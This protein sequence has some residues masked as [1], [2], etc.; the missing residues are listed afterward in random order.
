MNKS[1]LIVGQREISNKY[2]PYIIAEISA[3]H[4]GSI[5]CAKN[6]IMAA[7]K[8]GVHA[9]KIQTYTPDTMTIDVQKDD[10]L[11]QK[12]L[13][14][15]RSLYDLY[16]EAYTPF[17]WHKSLFSF[18][19]DINVTLFSSPFDE[20]AVDLLESLDVPA[21][22]IA[23]FEIVDLPLIRYV[24]NKQKPLLLSTGMASFDE[25][26]NAIDTAKTAGN[27]NIALFHCISS[28]PAELAESNLS[29]IAQLKKE[30]DVEVGLSDHTVG[31]LASVVATALGAS[32]IEKH[33]TLD[34]TKGGVDSSFSLEPSEMHALVVQTQEAF[35]AIGKPDLMRS[36]TEKNNK[37]FR[38]SLYFVNNIEVGEVITKHH[39]RRIRP[40]Y[41][42]EA[43][44][45]DEVI[46]SKNRVAAKRGDR[47]TLDHFR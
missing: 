17:E 28:Y 30:F 8:A 6:T 14:K 32:V 20:S 22:K 13:W 35:Q 34:R 4:N 27:H 18:A 47:V 39:V 24:A 26:A 45:Y 21:Y 9:V 41:G 2:P 11:I 29:A 3:N 10:F 1:K 38:R 7:K 44:F 46:G 16:R 25:I 42:L 43:K 19:K 5:E 31:H 15:G 23:S 33:F 36:D 37:I 12:G 40:G